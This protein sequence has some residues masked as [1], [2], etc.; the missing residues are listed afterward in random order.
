MKLADRLNQLEAEKAAAKKAA[1]ARPTKAAPSARRSVRS[2]Q[3][4]ATSAW[5]E[6]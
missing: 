6:V 2:G 3:K 1:P 5:D 4:S